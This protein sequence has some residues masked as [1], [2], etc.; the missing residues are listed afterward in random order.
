[1][2]APG[3][4]GRLNRLVGLR[5]NSFREKEEGSGR[6]EVGMRQGISRPYRKIMSG[7]V[8]KGGVVSLMEGIDTPFISGKFSS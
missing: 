6:G 8:R 4:W 7:T 3:G 2:T 1:V 5:V